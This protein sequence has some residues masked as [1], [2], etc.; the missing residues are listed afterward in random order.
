M[1]LL[2]VDFFPHHIVICV[3]LNLPL[4]KRIIHFVIRKRIELLVFIRLPLQ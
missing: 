3:I 1:Q 2:S 4:I